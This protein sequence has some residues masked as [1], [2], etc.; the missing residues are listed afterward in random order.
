MFDF[1]A[2]LITLGFVAFLFI[3]VFEGFLCAFGF[4]DFLV[5][6]GLIVAL[7]CLLIL[8]PVGDVL[9]WAGIT[10]FCVLDGCLL[11]FCECWRFGFGFLRLSMFCWV[12]DF[13]FG[14]W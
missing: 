8:V 13:N 6:F 4:G 5:Y 12:W 7:F 3:L 9:L 11:W 14:L 2:F 10:S 1:G